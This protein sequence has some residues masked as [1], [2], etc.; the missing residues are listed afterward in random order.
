M[1][2]PWSAQ[3]EVRAA[4]NGWKK[5]GSQGKVNLEAV[6]RTKLGA[7]PECSSMTHWL[8]QISKG[9][10]LVQGEFLHSFLKSKKNIPTPR[11]VHRA[12]M[13]WLEPQGCL[14]WGWAVPLS[15]QVAK[16]PKAYLATRRWLLPKTGGGGSAINY[17]AFLFA[18][19]PGCSEHPGGRGHPS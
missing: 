11:T 12:A 13:S 2:S 7:Y 10:R 5:L 1:S 15:L 16:K 17:T 8:E 19:A 3:E 9:L 4:S 14:D 18:A 6:V